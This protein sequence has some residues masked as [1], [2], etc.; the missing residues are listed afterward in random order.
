MDSF[1]SDGLFSQQPY[2]RS[3]CWN[4][5]STSKHWKRLAMFCILPQFLRLITSWTCSPPRY[6]KNLINSYN[7]LVK[8]SISQILVK[9][10][11]N[12]LCNILGMNPQTC[13]K[14]CLMESE[15]QLANLPKLPL[16]RQETMSGKFCCFHS[17]LRLSKKIN[18]DK[19]EALSGK[20]VLILKGLKLNVVFGSW[21]HKIICVKVKHLL[22]DKT[23]CQEFKI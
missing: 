15:F 9:T 11:Q 21:K 7:S 12:C 17:K 1:V 16:S 2:K 18:T 10:L 4:L 20:P 22:P 13:M 14:T 5:Q 6:F 3:W 8:N 23:V 19:L